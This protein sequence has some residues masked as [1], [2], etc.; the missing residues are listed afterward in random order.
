M[1][2]NSPWQALLLWFITIPLITIISAF[3]MIIVIIILE[4]KYK[5]LTIEQ[6]LILLWLFI[7]SVISIYLLYKLA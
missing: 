3:L 5:K 2:L 1:E 6:L 7:G 4:K